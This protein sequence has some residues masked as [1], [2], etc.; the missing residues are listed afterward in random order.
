MIEVIGMID[1]IGMEVGDMIIDRI[2]VGMEE[3]DGMDE[4]QGI[5]DPLDLPMVHPLD[6]VVRLQD[7]EH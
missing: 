5:I 4:T 2:M 1:M 6:L 3:M 7:L